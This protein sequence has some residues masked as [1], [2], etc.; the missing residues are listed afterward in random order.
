MY[1]AGTRTP[2]S[3]NLTFVNYTMIEN[4]HIVSKKIFVFLYVAVLCTTTGGQNR[5]GL[6]CAVMFNAPELPIDDEARNET[7]IASSGVRRY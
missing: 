5:Y 3:D 4:A 7:R 1:A 6:L 2:R